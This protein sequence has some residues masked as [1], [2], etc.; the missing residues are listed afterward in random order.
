M[1]HVLQREVGRGGRHFLEEDAACA[2][3]AELAGGKQGATCPKA[4]AVAG[5]ERGEAGLNFYSAFK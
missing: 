1:S 5:V 2:D 3:E 4:R